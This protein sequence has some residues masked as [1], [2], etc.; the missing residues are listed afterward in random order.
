MTDPVPYP[1][2]G[3]LERSCEQEETLR[4]VRTETHPDLEALHARFTGDVF[5]PHRHDSYAIGLTLGGVQRF[6]YRGEER[7]SMPGQILVLHPDEEHDGGAGS[8]ASLVYAMLYVSP[9]LVAQAMPGGRGALP[10]VPAP[11]LTDPALQSGLVGAF[12]ALETAT[13]APRP[14]DE[15]A[16][17]A[18]LAGITDAL[19][20]HSDSRA[21][22]RP[23]S[24]VPLRQ[25]ERA[26][27]LL[28]DAV[29]AP[30]SAAD[31][32]AATGL[33]R[34]SLSRAFRAVYGT[35][36]HRYLLMRRLT[37]ARRLIDGG[38]PLAQVAAEAGFADQSHLT[39]HFKK[40]FG[41]TPGRWNSLSSGTGAGAPLLT[42]P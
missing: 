9:A 34:F 39:R 10:F 16:L 27:S 17:T 21:G 25:V 22:G 36:P 19:C 35:S 2:P 4:M 42:L 11:V 5:E 3:G 40:A 30:L 23:G 26:R 32:E 18:L 14:E 41:L 31:L 13:A 8:D 20:R 38:L 24:R 1:A 7:R 15:L 37:F 28:D 6:F 12:S 29:A 33:D